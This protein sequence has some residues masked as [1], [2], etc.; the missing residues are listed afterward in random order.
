MM[1]CIWRLGG[2]QLMAMQ[3]VDFQ[4]AST[5]GAVSFQIGETLSRGGSGTNHYHSSMASLTGSIT[6]SRRAHIDQLIKDPLVAVSAQ[7]GDCLSELEVFG[8]I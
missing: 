3:S 2:S 1:T 7:S 8:L 4:M 6:A 5:S